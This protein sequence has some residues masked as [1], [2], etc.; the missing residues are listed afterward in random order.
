MIRVADELDPL[1]RGTPSRLF[2][3]IEVNLGVLADSYHGSGTSLG[4]GATL[5]FR[6]Y[7]SESRL[8]SI[9]RPLTETLAVAEAVLGI[10][11]LDDRA[12]SPTNVLNGAIGTTWYAVADAF[13]LPWLPYFGHEHMR[14]SF[15]VERLADGCVI[16]DGYENVT[17]WGRAKP[18]RWKLANDEFLMLRDLRL[19]T[20]VP[21]SR[22]LTSDL[23]P[24]LDQVEVASGYIDAYERCPDRAVALE[25]LCRETWLLERARSLHAAF[26]EHYGMSESIVVRE[27]LARWARL[28]ELVYITYRRVLR[29]RPEPIGYM[30]ELATLLE[31]DLIIFGAQP[32]RLP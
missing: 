3:C 28:V 14:H 17:N 12:A 31:E 15:L 4:I 6:T 10:K 19:M 21:S 32:S 22:V 23:L 11:V 8:P 7:P 30:A 2:D 5:R 29:G 1:F 9:E 16:T 24:G 27:H 18:G 13:H 26:R 25:T 20:I